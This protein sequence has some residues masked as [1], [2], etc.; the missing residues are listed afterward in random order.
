MTDETTQ[1]TQPQAITP[2]QL[3]RILEKG[4]EARREMLLNR[5]DESYA[6]K[7]HMYSDQIIMS[8]TLKMRASY[9]A[10]FIATELPAG[11][12]ME[13]ALNKLEEVT[14]WASKAISCDY[15]PKSNA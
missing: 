1:S 8:S 2:D 3:G 14:M 15:K 5:I 4:A 9:L 13:I 11:N 6:D 10:K 12:Y 7:K